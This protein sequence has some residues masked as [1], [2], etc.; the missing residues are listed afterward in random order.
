MAVVATG[1]G[2]FGRV[3]YR[4]RG[5]IPTLK[6]TGLA[7]YPVDKTRQPRKLHT[8]LVERF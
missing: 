7:I 4:A 8:N 5:K 6:S 3:S 2:I 1:F